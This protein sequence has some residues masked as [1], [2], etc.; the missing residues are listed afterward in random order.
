[1]LLA[2]VIATAALASAP[3]A[4]A[5]RFTADDRMTELISRS[6]GGGF[7]NGAS[8]NAAVAQDRQRASYVAYESDATDIV[9][10]DT[11]GAADVFLVARG[12]DFGLEGGP[13]RPGATRIVSR[14]R[15][16]GPANGPSGLPDIGGDQLH[17]PGCVAFVS[18]ASNLVPGDTNDRADALV[19]SLRTRRIERVSLATGGRE[20]DGDTFEVQVD[21]SCTRVAFVSD[22][23]NL[24]LT[25]AGSGARR[26]ARTTRP[27][28]GTRQVYVRVLS[29][30][31]ANA[32][33]SP[34]R[35]SWPRRRRAGA[36]AT[37]TPGMCR[38]P[39]SAGRRAV[40]GDAAPAWA[41]RSRSTRPRRT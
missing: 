7:P 40:R 13:W 26:G 23:T 33:H 16:G 3:P 1:M 27:P 31:G 30:R 36:L 24:A 14:A 12:G 4:H 17:A 20:S 34:A 37:A 10:G 15:D 35:R 11:N 38:S 41:R 6:A 5:G 22:A 32:G 29:G 2:A 8:R 18:R 21:G 19:Y 28:R 39:S 25:R 9:A